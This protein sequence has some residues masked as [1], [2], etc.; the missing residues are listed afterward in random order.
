MS[1]FFFFNNDWYWIKTN[2]GNAKRGISCRLKIWA[3]DLVLWP[4]TLKINRVPDLLRTKY[5][6][7]FVKIHWRMLILECSQGCYGRTD[8]SITIS[9]RNFVSEGIFWQFH[10]S[11]DRIK[12]PSLNFK[13]C[14]IKFLCPLLYLQVI[15]VQVP[16]TCI[17]LIT[18]EREIGPLKREVLRD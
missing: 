5:V 4:M 11:T 6:P 15:H 8:G 9:I 10:T 13:I 3:S 7:S 14:N 16:C 18:T 2:K 1:I 17:L 12:N